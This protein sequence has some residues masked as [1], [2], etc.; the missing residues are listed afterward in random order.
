[1]Q[2]AHEKKYIIETRT[3]T[4]TN[5]IIKKCR[6]LTLTFTT[7]IA[8]ACSPYKN[9]MGWFD[10]DKDKDQD[11]DLIMICWDWNIS[12][13]P[14]RAETEIIIYLLIRIDSIVVY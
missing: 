8:P 14:L 5:R 1:M 6:L 3:V 12:V 13:S 11:H 10:Q 9:D 2:T 7:H 4:D